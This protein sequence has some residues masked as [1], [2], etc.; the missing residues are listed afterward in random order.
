MIKYLNNI[1]KFRRV[2]NSTKIKGILQC[3]YSLVFEKYSGEVKKIIMKKRRNIK[4]KNFICKGV[5]EMKAKFL[6]FT[7]ICMSIFT[8]SMFDVSVKRVCQ[9]KCVSFF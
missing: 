3:K 5:F 1:E 4:R 8:F 7:A 9:V 2:T 6:L